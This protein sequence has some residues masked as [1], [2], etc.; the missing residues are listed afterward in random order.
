M[1]LEQ[2]KKT[3]QSQ[4][5]RID[6]LE[7]QN[8]ELCRTVRAD[9]LLGRRSRLLRTYRWLIIAGLVTIP[10]ILLAFPRLDIPCGVTVLFVVTMA[11]LA[12]FNSYVY[13]LIMRIDPTAM[14]MRDTLAR[15]V[16]LEV[17]RRRLRRCS[18]AIGGVAVA[19][20][21][22]VL[23]E[24]GDYSPLIGGVVGGMAGAICGLRK[25]AEIKAQIRAMKE[26]L[27]DALRED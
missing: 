3:W 18:M 16:R 22:Y 5:V 17:A 11:V 23:Y 13:R 19:F 9:R 21:L 7:E 27:R 14:S 6:R 25:E 10:F 12:L 8:R 24:K 1:D 15:V 26:M 2:L 4:S 20:F